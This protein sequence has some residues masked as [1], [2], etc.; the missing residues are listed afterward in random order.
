MSIGYGYVTSK[1]VDP[2]L[3]L[4]SGHGA[5]Y[6]AIGYL[7]GGKTVSYY[8]RKE[9]DKNRRVWYCSKVD[10]TM[11]WASSKVADLYLPY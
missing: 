6:P 9:K 5:N 8:G 4:R 2:H 11:C 10:G 7:F 3:N 1:D